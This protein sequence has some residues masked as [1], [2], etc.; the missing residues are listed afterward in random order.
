MQGAGLNFGGGGTPRRRDGGGYWGGGRFGG[1]FRGHR[2]FRGGYRGGRGGYN[3]YGNEYR[4]YRDG[5]PD[6]EIVPPV[7][8]PDEDFDFSENL[9]KFNKSELTSKADDSEQV[10]ILVFL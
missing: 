8:V 5:Y 2:G 10:G 9:A 1:G 3:R 6:K 7:K 4:G